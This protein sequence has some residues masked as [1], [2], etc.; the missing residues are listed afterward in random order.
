MHCYHCSSV[1]GAN[2]AFCGKCGAQLGFT[3]DIILAAIAKEENAITYLYNET[4][5]S[6]FQAIRP[7][8][9]DEDTALDILQ[10]TYIKAFESLAQLEKPE[11]F[12]AWVKRIAQNKSKDWLKKKK[13]TLFSEMRPDD[14]DGEIDFLDDREFAQP[15]AIM[16]KKE[17]RRLL[18]D[19]IDSLSD[20]Q[21]L[22]VSMYYFQ[23]MQV[24]DIAL[25]LGIAEN[26]VKSR[27]NYARKHIETKVLALE[28]QGTK[29]YSL[30]PL[31]F[32]LWLI[33]SGAE[34]P[35]VATLSEITGSLGTTGSAAATASSGATATSAAATSGT[36][37]TGATSAAA[38][39][40][41][42]TKIIVGIVAAAIAIG[43]GALLYQALTPD[44][45]PT[46]VVGQ[47][48]ETQGVTDVIPESEADVT[49][50]P[51]Q[52]PDLE[53][54]NAERIA[55][56]VAYVEDFSSGAFALYDVDGD[57]LDELLAV[58]SN[59]DFSEITSYVLTVNEQGEIQ[60]L[61]ESTDPSNN[62]RAG[63]SFTLLDYQGQEYFAHS[64]SAAS[65]MMESMHSQGSY[66]LLAAADGKIDVAHV[67]DWQR[68][69]NMAQEETVSA[70]QTIDGAPMDDAELANVR[71]S[72]ADI[73]DINADNGMS[74]DDFISVYK[75]AATITNSVSDNQIDYTGYSYTDSYPKTYRIE[76]VGDKIRLSYATIIIDEVDRKLIQDYVISGRYVGDTFVMEQVEVN[77]Q[78]FTS[79]YDK[80]DFAFY[81]D[82]VELNIAMKYP[83]TGLPHGTYTLTK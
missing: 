36:A 82:R 29:L 67:I 14:E 61:F 65:L 31:P 22:V 44:N 70:S 32:L 66:Q 5:N 45:E 42:V 63:A 74:R 19:I 11:Q 80:F 15:D 75:N 10:D 16:D 64:Y 41:I 34:T 21:R 72:A 23:E 30:A 7:L 4:Y 35:S 68:V 28:K 2:A 69:Y 53:V 50:A 79:Q 81:D 49:P 59:S 60:V 77:G 9:K 54:L 13:P 51:E 38:G 1:T 73:L 33:R 24:K 48:D 17:T 37:A 46:E 47:I 56:F 57:G 40:S 39:A 6:V 83:V 26:T 18:W 52:T 8:I 55:A 62:G 12:R 3:E 43:G 76:D 27:L 71:E 20:E 78:D 58:L 25:E